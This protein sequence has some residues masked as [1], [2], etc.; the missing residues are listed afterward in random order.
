[1][2]KLIKLVVLIVAS[3]GSSQAALHLTIYTGSK[4]FSFSGSD[5]GTPVISYGWNVLAWE[6][7]STTEWGSGYSIT[8]ASA[9][10]SDTGAITFANFSI[11]NNGEIMLNIGV[12]SLEPTV[13]ST[14]S[15]VRL[16]YAQVPEE[17]QLMLEDFVLNEGVLFSS[18]GSG[19]HP[20]T[21][22]AVPEPSTYAL[23]G[24]CTA[25]IGLRLMRRHRVS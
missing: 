22:E 3:V 7:R 20:V 25:M 24:L 9:F 13:I 17:Y 18:L 4:E 12:S 11:V 21:S 23:L 10:S 6:G 19:T 8:S 2:H 1:M 16:S 14:N 15:P 5:G